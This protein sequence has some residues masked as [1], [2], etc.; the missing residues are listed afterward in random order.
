MKNERAMHDILKVKGDTASESADIPSTWEQYS[1]AIS[2]LESLGMSFADA[3]DVVDA[4]LLR[5]GIEPMVLKSKKKSESTSSI[6][7]VEPPW[8][9]VE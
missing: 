7:D 8:D 3:Q 6:S 2:E 1:K 4:D 5:A 9:G